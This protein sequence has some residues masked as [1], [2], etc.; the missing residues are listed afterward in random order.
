M[1]FSNVI[2]Y[3]NNIFKGV[4]L[5]YND[6][7][8]KNA[9]IEINISNESTF[10]NESGYFEFDNIPYDTLILK[11]SAYGFESVEFTAQKEEKNIIV[12]S[13][14]LLELKSVL[15]QGN[16]FATLRNYAAQKVS[17]TSFEV[18]TSPTAFGDLIGA[19]RLS[20]GAQSS[21][22]D[23]RLYIRGGV[24]DESK[25]FVNEMMVFNPYTLKQ[26][27][28]STR[29]RFSPFLYQGISLQS[30]GYEANYGQALS[31]VLSMKTIDNIESRTDINITSVGVSSG[32]SVN[33]KSSSQMYFGIDYTNLF[34]YGTIFKDS[35]KWNKYFN[36]LSGEF[37]G[38]FKLSKKVSVK[39]YLNISSSSVDYSY[40]NID[41]LQYSN[42]LSENYLWGQITVEYQQN[43]NLFWFFGS[44]FINSEFSGTDVNQLSDNVTTKIKFNNNKSY[45]RYSINNFIFTSGFESIFTGYNQNYYYKDNYLMSFDNFL[46]AHFYNIE[47]N[48]NDNTSMSL[49]LR[50][51]YSLLMQ[52]HNIAPRFYLAKNLKK[53]SIIS[54]SLGWYYQDPQNDY[55][56]FNKQLDFENTFGSTLSY[57]YAL[58]KS[59]FQ[60]DIYYKKYND[61]TTFNLE[62]FRPTLIE[63]KGFGY[64]CGADIFYKGN[65]NNFEYIVSYSHVNSKRIYQNF[66]N[67]RFPAL[68]SPNA[69]KFDGKYWISQI[70]SLIGISYFIDSGSY[71]YF[72]DPTST[73]KSPFRNN[74]NLDISYLPKRNLIIHASIRN[75]FGQK[76]VYGYEYSRINNDYIP[77][78]TPSTRFYYIG[79]FL[80]ISKYNKRNQLES[81]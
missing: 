80:T 47:Y 34:P 39:S 8:I 31:G 24:P 70:K 61:L 2:A 51:E 30:G 12:L 25:V 68:L 26:R 65:I 13:L 33:K 50:G 3:S 52:K 1:L 77:I 5:D 64:A 20:P 18:Y 37:Y 59:K 54:L 78:N 29:S 36:N 46:L 19:L 69:L 7:P 60:L 45:F 17:L 56:K 16:R 41:S 57:V 44:N 49:G 53:N 58:K 27:N 72:N 75:I 42:N 62:D 11:I 74:M 21:E 9:T 79:I 28:V 55:L 22:N 6:K 71:S 66:S 10:T 76:N 48:I 32:I 23:G 38:K 35:Y 81:F 40:I 73:I 67:Y 63:N 43:K 15:V 14:R 4:V